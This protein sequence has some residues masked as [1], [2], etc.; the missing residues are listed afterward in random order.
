[1]PLAALRLPLE[2]L[3]DLLDGVVLG[4]AEPMLAVSY[5]NRK[6]PGV[7]SSVSDQ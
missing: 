5:P 4:S 1:M 2:D 3:D 6:P 7:A